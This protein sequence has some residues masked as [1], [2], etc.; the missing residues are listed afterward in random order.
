MTKH[1]VTAFDTDLRDLLLELAQMAGWVERA[2]EDA[3]DALMTGATD[4]AESVIS[5]DDR[6]DDADRKVESDAVLLIARRQPM[7]DDLRVIVSSMR[8]SQDLERVGDLAKNIAKRA[9]IIDGS[10]HQ[11]TLAH[12]VDSLSRLVLGQLKRSIEAFVERDTTKA[13]DVWRHDAEVDALYTSLFRE[14]LTYMMEDPRN[15][16]SC[17]HLL[18][19][20]KNLERIGDHATNIAER[21]I[22][23]RTGEMVATNRPKQDELG[24]ATPET[25]PRPN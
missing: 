5:N 13:E 6:I 9:L 14:L 18:F 19:C 8:V 1:I 17:T 21:A 3:V 23:T 25:T 12:G 10:I 4:E 24:D 22:Y 15:I 7:G 20:A 11:R 2:V 16:S